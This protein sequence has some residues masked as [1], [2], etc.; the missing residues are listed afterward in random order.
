MLWSKGMRTMI[1]CLG[2]E[3]LWSDDI[4][5]RVGR[6]LKV[7][8]LPSPMMVRIVP[9]LDW[10]SV[11]AIA[12]CDQTIVVDAM[13]SRQEPGTCFVEEASQDSAPTFRLYCRHRQMVN[14]IVELDRLLATEG[15]RKRLVFIGVEG[16]GVRWDESH[17]DAASVSAVPLAVDS[18]LRS[19][20]GTGPQPA[21]NT[22]G[23]PSEELNFAAATEARLGDTPPAPT[24]DSRKSLGATS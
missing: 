14:D 4:A 9:R 20:P 7:L 13:D 23:L 24:V 6:I 16:G 11:D 18:V 12:D 17:S 19:N 1:L 8:P 5:A 22:W 2:H 21:G 15:S 10:D 3:R